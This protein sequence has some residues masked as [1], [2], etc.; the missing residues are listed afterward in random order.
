M[1]AT[2]SRLRCDGALWSILQCISINNIAGF[3]TRHH[4]HHFGTLPPTSNIFCSL[5]A[6]YDTHICILNSTFLSSQKEGTRARQP[7]IPPSV[8]PFTITFVASTSSHSPIVSVLFPRTRWV[9]ESTHCTT[10]T[11]HGLHSK[12]DDTW[13]EETRVFDGSRLCFRFTALFLG[14][15]RWVWFRQMHIVTLFC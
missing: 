12:R 8:C 1:G 10:L 15:G 2:A 7:A 5:R 14:P 4:F 6:S 13:R 9:F 3:R 11:T